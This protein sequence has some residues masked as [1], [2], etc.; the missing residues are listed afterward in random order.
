MC[1]RRTD[2]VRR[3]IICGQK[4]AE[5]DRTR[6]GYHVRP[7]EAAPEARSSACA[8]ERRKGSDRSEKAAI[9]P[10]QHSN[11]GRRRRDGPNTHRGIP[12]GRPDQLGTRK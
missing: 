11:F 1:S 7:H 2:S 3:L 9:E 5:A 10:L 8:E 4:A 12:A 6:E